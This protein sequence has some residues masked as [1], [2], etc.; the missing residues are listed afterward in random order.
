M[1]HDPMMRLE[2][3]GQ[4]DDVHHPYTAFNQG[5]DAADQGLPESLN[6][7]QDDPREF[8]WWGWGYDERQEQRA[9]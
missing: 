6:P 4:S 9:N 2:D 1:C 7:Y 3:D 5:Y 8:L